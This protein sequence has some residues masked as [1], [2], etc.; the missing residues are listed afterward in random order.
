MSGIYTPI[1]D[2]TS[3]IPKSG[4]Q[5]MNPREYE[6]YEYLSRP[7]ICYTSFVIL[8]DDT[9]YTHYPEIKRYTVK[10]DYFSTYSG[11]SQSQAELAVR[12]LN[13]NID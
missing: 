2:Q 9:S 4:A 6:I 10:T 3:W 8:D 11:L 5:D 7:S 12:L 13:N 1:Y